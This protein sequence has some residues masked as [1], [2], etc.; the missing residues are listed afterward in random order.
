MNLEIVKVFSTE[1]GVSRFASETVRLKSGAGQFQEDSTMMSP[2]ES[3]KRYF[4]VKLPAGFS[5]EQAFAGRR[6][7]CVLLSGRVEIGTPDGEA[8][9][10]G[11]GETVMLED[12]EA[13]A[14]GRSVK[15]VGDEPAL[16]L[17]V[18]LD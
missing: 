8:I 5:D 10:F 2:A 11:A 4:F 6:Q 1:D 17:T 12:T 9:G 13:T 18:Q 14:P 16:I 15:V 3:C 7:L